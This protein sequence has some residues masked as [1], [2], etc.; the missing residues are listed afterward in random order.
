MANIETWVVIIA[1]MTIALCFFSVVMVLTKRSERRDQDYFLAMFLAI[2]GLMKFDQLYLLT[3]GYALWP[4]VAGIMFSL[5]LLLPAIMYFYT[6]SLTFPT[7]QWLRQK[8]A[9][10]L[11]APIIAALVASPYYI[12]SGAAKN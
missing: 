4:H 5:K 7:V 12:L 2:Y 8:D 1:S 6:R 3:Q 9:H 10:A 11:L